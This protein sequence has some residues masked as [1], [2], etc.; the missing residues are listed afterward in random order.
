MFTDHSVLKYL[1]NK[2]VLG[3][4]ICRW[5]LLFQE[6]DFEIV[7]KPGRMNKGPDHLSRL[8]NG[9]EP[10]SLEDTLPDA[11][12]LAIRKVDDHFAEIVQFLSTGMAPREYTIIQKK[13]LVVRAADFSLISGKLYKMGPDEILRRCVMEAERPLILVEAH[14]G[15][16]GG[17]YAGKATTHKVLRAG[18]WWATLHKDAKEYYRACDVC[19]RVGKPYRR[20]EM[21]L[22]PHLTLQEFEKW[23]IDF[24]GPINPPGKHKGARYIITTTEYLTRW[25]RSKSSQ[26]L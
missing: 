3:G 24:V 1:V 9:E 2:P 6:Y 10:T 11:Q 5:L 4:R 14:E 19:Q 22:A 21:P 26:G 8:E 20:Y 12:L 17:H 23:T 16:T 15:I 7:V 25:A 13:Q 18:L